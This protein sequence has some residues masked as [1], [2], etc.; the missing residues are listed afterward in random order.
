MDHGLQLLIMK[1]S[2]YNFCLVVIAPKF[3]KLQLKAG[4]TTINGSSLTKLCTLLMVL[5]G[6]K[7]LMEK[8]MKLIMIEIQ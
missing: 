6:A 5:I 1:A 4:Q 8:Y 3:W 7:L 2:T